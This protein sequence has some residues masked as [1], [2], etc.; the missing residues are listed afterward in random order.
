ME[1]PP[2]VLTHDF[3]YAIFDEWWNKPHRTMSF[4]NFNY[5]RG[6][7]HPIEDEV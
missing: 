6:R 1:H 3:Y 5:W 7:Y 4:R 2:A